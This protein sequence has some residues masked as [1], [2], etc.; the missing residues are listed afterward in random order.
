MK[1]AQAANAE[2]TSSVLALTD[3]GCPR[4]QSP[5]GIAFSS[6]FLRLPTRAHTK[7]VRNRAAPPGLRHT[8]AKASKAEQG[9][10]GPGT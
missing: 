1:T 3:V 8:R 4:A 9:G 5:A 6:R 10:T 7:S 2:E